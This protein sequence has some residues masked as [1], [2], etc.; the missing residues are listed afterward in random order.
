MLQGKL[1]EAKTI[2]LAKD[3]KLIDLEG[4]LSTKVDYTELSKKMLDKII[5][6]QEWAEFAIEFGGIYN[7]FFK[8]L[9]KISLNK[10]TKNELRLCSLI[11]LNL[12]NKEMADLLYI[13]VDG[14]KKAKNRLS[15]KINLKENKQLSTR[16]I[17][18]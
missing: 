18:L 15:K 10:L 9:E 14:V 17:N 4:E 8:N 16:I 6:S 1:N 11:K 12:S 3:Q 2:I 5:D 13:S 7:D